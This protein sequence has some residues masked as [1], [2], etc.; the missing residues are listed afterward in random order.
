MRVDSEKVNHIAEDIA[1]L[2]RPIEDLRPDP[3]NARKHSQE[4]IRAIAESLKVFGQQTPIKILKDGTVIKGNGTL[5]AAKTLGW[6]SLAAS[7][8]DAGSTKIE[9][10]S[11]QDNRTSDLATWDFGAL[12]E[13]IPNMADLYD[14]EAMGWNQY[15]ID[16]LL[17]TVSSTDDEET[18]TV[19]ASPETGKKAAPT[20]NLTLALKVTREQYEIINAAVEE[21]RDGDDNMDAAKA[22]AIVCQAYTAKKGKTDGRLD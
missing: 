16:A 22:L 3:D 1:H 5:E 21:A 14:L 2:S 8:F 12:A 10:Y 13:K 7:V 15:E 11:I 20:D 6:T 17:E 18:P 19:G 9:G 4:N